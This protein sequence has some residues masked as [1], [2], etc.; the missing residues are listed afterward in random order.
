MRTHLTP[1]GNLPS[2]TQILSATESPEAQDKLRKWQQK[3]DKIHGSGAAEAK[4]TAAKNRGIILHDLVKN[5][6]NSSTFSQPENNIFWNNL[7]PF[8][9][10]IKN[11]WLVCEH[12]VWS[13]YGYSGICDLVA[14]IDNQVTLVDWKTS[15]RT[16]R[17]DWIED[18]FIQCAA[19][20]MA[21]NENEVSLECPEHMNDITQ[22]AVVV[23]SP[24]KLQVFTEEKEN[25][26]K[27]QALWLDRLAIFK[28]MVK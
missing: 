22:L 14:K 26:K 27:Y 18:Y 19:Y 28:K 20:A 3:M 11:D 2:V 7:H 23:I 17:R 4:S 13:K 25:V 15:K 1:I 16:K 10:S 6:L 21:Y 8:L 9:K 12:L 24:N 5:Y